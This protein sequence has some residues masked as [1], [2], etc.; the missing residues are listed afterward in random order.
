[1]CVFGNP[2]IVC[3]MFTNDMI[4]PA[5]QYVRKHDTQRNTVQLQDKCTIIQSTATTVPRFHVDISDAT[6]N[7]SEVIEIVAI[8]AAMAAADPDVISSKSSDPE[9][10]LRDKFEL[11]F[12]SN[13]V[14]R[15]YD[16]KS[17]EITERSFQFNVH[18]GDKKRNQERRI[19]IKNNGNSS[20]NMRIVNWDKTICIAS[21]LQERYEEI[22]KVI[23][24]CIYKFLHTRAGLEKT[25]IDEETGEFVFLSKDFLENDEK[26]MV[27]IHGSGM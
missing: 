12:D 26:L 3:F 6:L 27:I 11:G 7:L 22:G 13:G 23:D 21:F 19:S 2:Y 5:T 8:C 9:D 14:L 17:S 24:R 16:N 15:Q 18:S 10:E 4:C 1:M 20:I 25:V